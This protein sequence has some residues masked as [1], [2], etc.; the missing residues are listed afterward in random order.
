[1]KGTAHT[2]YV[3]HLQLK[4]VRATKR[5][6]NTAKMTIA[7]ITQ[8]SIPSLLLGHSLPPCTMGLPASAACLLTAARY[9]VERCSTRKYRVSLSC[10]LPRAIISSVPQLATIATRR[11]ANRCEKEL[12]QPALKLLLPLPHAPPPPVNL[13]SPPPLSV[14]LWVPEGESCI[15]LHGVT[16]F[17]HRRKRR[18]I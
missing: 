9:Y 8:V 7:M 12:S 16:S 4:L 11:E 3:L 15:S 13:F 1:M 17:L 18:H 14:S 10:R 6:T 5:R 2:Q